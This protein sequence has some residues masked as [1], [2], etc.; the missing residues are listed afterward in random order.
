[1]NASKSPETAIGW[2]YFSEPMTTT[3]CLRLW[4]SSVIASHSLPFEPVL[5]NS[6]AETPTVSKRCVTQWSG[7]AAS[8]G[9]GEH[10]VSTYWNSPAFTDLCRGPHVPTTGKL[11]HF[12]LMRVAGAYW[13]GDEKRQQLQRIYGT[14]WDSEKALA[15]HLHRLA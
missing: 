12:A 6:K 13:R 1:M 11:G 8:E 14:A 9:A 2:R 15:G 4:P 10:G 3:L 5:P 7:R